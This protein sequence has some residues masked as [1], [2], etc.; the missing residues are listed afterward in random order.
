MDDCAPVYGGADSLY[1]TEN[2]GSTIQDPE[3]VSELGRTYH[4]YKDGK[5]L[6]PNDAVEQ[7][8]MDLCHGA[9]SQWLGGCLHLAPIADVKNVLDLGTGTGIWALEFAELYPNANITGT[10]LSRI[11]PSG[12]RANV[13]WVQEDAEDDWRGFT[14]PF[15]FIHMRGMFTCFDDPKAVMRRAYE[16]LSPGGWIEY[17]DGSVNP[18]CQDT[19]SLGTSVHRWAFML[20]EGGR[21]L[22]KLTP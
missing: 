22:G 1:Y 7:D 12:V 17:Q 8:R 15:D 21:R 5:Y 3:S 18:Y 14:Q 19:S 11:Q 16:H 13:K 9:W 2:P 6:L 20:K 4:G 10:D